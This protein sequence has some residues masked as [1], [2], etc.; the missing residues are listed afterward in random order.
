MGVGAGIQTGDSMKPATKPAQDLGTRPPRPALWPFP[1]PGHDM[2]AALRANQ[3][4]ARK[5]AKQG[6]KGFEQAPF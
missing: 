1:P 5:E 2:R 3:R 4:K 6:P